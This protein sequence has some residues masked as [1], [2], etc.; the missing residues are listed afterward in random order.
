MTLKLNDLTPKDLR[1]L[2]VII[3]IA[4]AGAILIV[5]GS[6]PSPTSWPITIWGYELLMLGAGLLIHLSLK[7]RIWWGGLVAFPAAGMA[8]W[9]LADQSIGAEA[10][11]MVLK[12]SG[13]ALLVWGLHQIVCRLQRK[14][15]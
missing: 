7:H 9:L 5:V 11:Q 10:G 1:A 2:L 4:C 12:G 14:W 15:G 8:V 6:W 13:A 3:L